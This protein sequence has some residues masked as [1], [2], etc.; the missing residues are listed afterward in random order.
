MGVVN[1]KN[2]S[3]N[4]LDE[5]RNWLENKGY[6][7][8]HTY[9]VGSVYVNVSQKISDE[10]LIKFKNDFKCKLS[11]IGASYNGS[12]EISKFEYYCDHLMLKR[13]RGYLDQ[14]LKDNNFPVRFTTTSRDIRMICFNKLS[15]EQISDF[16]EEF[17]VKYGG[18]SLSCNSSDVSY[19]FS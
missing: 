6:T 5:I 8:G 15:K 17:E 10:D 19:E 7:C 4:V 1:I 18:Y 3:N 16:E 11:L 9:V 12:D 14:W 13:F 2:P